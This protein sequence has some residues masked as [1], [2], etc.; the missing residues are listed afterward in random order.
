MGNLINTLSVQSGLSPSDVRLILR[1][2]PR[3]YKVYSIPK[4]S[5]GERIIAQPAREVKLLQRAL[6][7]TLLEN[8]P[9]HENAKAY[10]MGTSLLDNAQPH[11][12]Q[13]PILK[14]DFAD[15]FPSIHGIDWL[16]Y[17]VQ[18][19]IL[20]RE[21]SVLSANLLFRLAKHERTLKLSI[22]APS[23]PLISNILMYKFDEIILREATKRKISY[24]R[25]A[26][27]LT[28][29]GQRVGMLK[30]MPGI[31]EKAIREAKG[32]RLS[33]N[34]SK[35]TYVTSRFQRRV[36]GLVLA[37]DGT[38]GIGRDKK[39]LIRSKVHRAIN[40]KLDAKQASELAG[41]LAY[42]NSVDPE[43]ILSLESTYGIKVF[44]ELIPKLLSR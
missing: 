43:L 15:F 22:G 14:I 3:R 30:D 2:A 41:Y 37:N 34:K 28:F 26:D 18:S 44:G 21:D 24:T 31:V 5:G 23:S 42:V 16:R 36:T 33:I 6:M 38:V 25:Y 32:P 17:C 12:G 10:K 29:S 19:A 27:D 35:T 39:R 11:S 1:T 8:L 4:K 20:D 40:G 7:S 9:V 13:S